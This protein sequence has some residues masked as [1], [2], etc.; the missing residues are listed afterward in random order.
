MWPP[1]RFGLACPWRPSALGLARP[2]RPRPLAP[3]A[4]LDP[5]GP[6]VVDLTPPEGTSVV[7]PLYYI[8]LAALPPISTHLHRPDFPQALPLMRSPPFPSPFR[9]PLFAAPPCLSS[10]DLP[11]PDLPAVLRLRFTAHPP[12]FLSAL[13]QLTFFGETSTSSLEANYPRLALV[14]YSTLASIY[15]CSAFFSPNALTHPSQRSLLSSSALSLVSSPS[16]SPCLPLKPDYARTMRRS[17]M[18]KMPHARG[19][20]A[21]VSS[22]CPLRRSTACK[23]HRPIAKMTHVGEAERMMDDIYCARMSARECGPLAAERAALS[24]EHCMMSAEL[25]FYEIRDSRLWEARLTRSRLFVFQFEIMCVLAELDVVYERTADEEWPRR[26]GPGALATRNKKFDGLSGGLETW[27]VEVEVTVA[28]GWVTSNMHPHP[29]ELNVHAARVRPAIS[30]RCTA[31]RRRWPR[32]AG[33]KAQFKEANMAISLDKIIPFQ[34]PSLPISPDTL[35][36]KPLSAPAPAGPPPALLP[37]A[38]PQ[39]LSHPQHPLPP[40]PQ[41]SPLPESTSA[42]ERAQQS[43]KKQIDLGCPFSDIE[44]LDLTG[45]EHS[46]IETCDGPACTVEDDASKQAP[47]PAHQLSLEPYSGTEYTQSKF[48]GNAEILEAV[49]IPES[50]SLECSPAVPAAEDG[51]ESPS[52]LRSQR[53]VDVTPGGALA[54]ILIDSDDDE[55]DVEGPQGTADNAHTEPLPDCGALEPCADPRD[56]DERI[57]G[58]PSPSPSPS[59][60]QPLRMVAVEVP[61][62]RVTPHAPSSQCPSVPI[63]READD[64]EGDGDSGY[65]DS[66]GE[67]D[68][69]AA[70]KRRKVAIPPPSAC[71]APSGPSSLPA[72]AIV[73]LTLGIS[74][75]VHPCIT[76]H[77]QAYAQG[78][79]RVANSVV[80]ASTLGSDIISAVVSHLMGSPVVTGSIAPDRLG[81]PEATRCNKAASCTDGR[82]T[83]PRWSEAE[84]NLLLSLMDDSQPLTEAVAAERLPGRSWASVQQRRSIL[85]KDKKAGDKKLSDHAGSM[86]AL[87]E[88]GDVRLFAEL[89]RACPATLDNDGIFQLGGEDRV[90]RYTRWDTA[91]LVVKVGWPPRPLSLGENLVA[92]SGRQGI[93]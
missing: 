92:S 38:V 32:E 29:I 73:S 8:R 54:P 25:V 51:I 45:L 74:S 28:A 89:G 1:S 40:K 48:D 14:V 15:N 18:A 52:P 55:T 37:K 41:F 63:A 65:V 6:G 69:A 10:A 36:L 59:S 91:P 93:H 77:I 76:E 42:D 78:H 83:A 68:V 47:R 2:L 49:E 62:R 35:P 26:P 58:E 71:R 9:R 87:I 39:H 23:L 34:P 43:A 53:P 80:D 46:E 86:F 13:L 44:F 90:D 30:A 11:S 17:P 75:V 19:V 81:D 70:S 82:G 61:A 24:P 72:D 12:A 66:E 57:K 22:G 5:I 56:E 88:E 3:P 21:C 85:R 27:A 16:L 20:Q 64:N 31:L 60:S 4:L 50:P 67:D 79:G 84:I 33:N 7:L